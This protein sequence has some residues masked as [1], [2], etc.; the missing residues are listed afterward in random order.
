MLTLTA[1]F[2][3]KALN[4]SL[5]QL[6]NQER[7][8]APLAGKSLQVMVSDFNLSCYLFITNTQCQ[9]Y[10]N[11][12]LDADCTLH[13]PLRELIRL[14]L[15][16]T[17]QAILGADDV[18]I[19]GDIQIL[20]SIQALIGHLGTAFE[21]QL[22]T[23]LTLAP[24]YS[25]Y[26]LIKTVGQKHCQNVKITGKEIRNYLQTSEFGLVQREEVDEF[27]QHNQQ[28]RQD[29]ERLEA[30]LKAATPPRNSS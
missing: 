6:E 8:L 15:S 5:K 3:E 20:Q 18:E 26:S 27:I 13:A 17:P 25:G 22:A 29:I 1:S 2:I 28:L 4:Q 11:S 21:Q 10:F 16:T 30:R 19:A 7:L 9:F 23:S 12:D 14:S 24:L